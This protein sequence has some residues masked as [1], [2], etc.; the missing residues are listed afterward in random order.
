[1]H[2]TTYFAAKEIQM[3]EELLKKINELLLF[4][5]QYEGED[6]QMI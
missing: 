4:A 3:F 5:S 6:F 2:P 1:M